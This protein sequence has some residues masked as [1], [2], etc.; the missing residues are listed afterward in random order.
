MPAPLLL[1]LSHTC[2]TRART[3]IQRVAR[4]LHSALGD[5]ALAITHDPHRHAWRR[6]EAWELANLSATGAHLWSKQFGSA[7]SDTGTAVCIVPAGG[8][9]LGG[10]FA[11]IGIIFFL[12]GRIPQRWHAGPPVEGSLAT[13]GSL[14]I[15][16]IGFYII[17]LAFFKRSRDHTQ[18]DD[19]KQT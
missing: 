17:F 5:D 7:G 10:S 13:F 11:G 18:K 6:L 19:T 16:L 4:A 15:V 2:H 8:V 9:I 14:L 12:A 3:G 1:D